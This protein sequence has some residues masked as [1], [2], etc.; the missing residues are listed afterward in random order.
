MGSGTP[1]TSS[2]AGTNDFFGLRVAMLRLS[3]VRVGPSRRRERRL[4]VRRSEP[5]GRDVAI[6]V[7]PPG[8]VHIIART[9]DAGFGLPN[10]GK[11]AVH[12]RAAGNT[13]RNELKVP[14]Q[15]VHPRACG[16]HSGACEKH[17]NYPVH[18]RACGEHSAFTFT[19]PSYPG[20]SPACGEHRRR[21]AMSGPPPVHPRAC[22]EH[23]GRPLR[24]SKCH[25]SSP[26][27]RGTLSSGRV[28][29]EL[30]RF[31]PARAG[32]TRPATCRSEYE[33][34]IPARAG[35]TIRRSSSRQEPRFIPARAG[36]TLSC[37]ASIAPHRFIPARAGNTGGSR[38]LLI[39]RS[40]SSPRVRG[41]HLSARCFRRRQRFIPARA[42]N[43]H[44]PTLNRAVATVHPRAC[45]EH[46]GIPAGLSRYPVH[47]RACGEHDAQRAS[48]PMYRR[49][50]PARAGNTQAGLAN[51]SPLAVHPRAC[52]EHRSAQI[53]PRCLFGSSPRVRG[54]RAGS[55]Q[56]HSVCGSSP[57]VRGTPATRLGCT[58]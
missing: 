18:P 1:V 5:L 53:F 57:R 51:G 9:T 56:R 41:T 38:H 8:S 23:S 14:R 15:T 19:S 44:D 24:S 48:G 12:P 21:A 33:R 26:R 6:A 20:S 50:I 11:V 30:D 28:D 29:L 25:G 36:N 45:G 52:G 35:N 40:G 58:V 49:F 43:T 42:G 3:V 17:A 13:L 39:E 32:N 54:T 46:F 27:V 2:A 31:I 7:G 4:T 55:L 47:P 10:V 22:G 37:K 34:F 16:E